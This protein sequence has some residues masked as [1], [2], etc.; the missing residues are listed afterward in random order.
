MKIELSHD[1]LAKRIYD[2]A[3]AEDKMLLRIR[4]LLQDH[5]VNKKGERK[6]LLSK[7]DLAYI[8]P[9]LDSMELSP[10]EVE[11]INLSKKVIQQR[12]HRFYTAFVFFI[13]V[14][15]VINYTARRYKALNDVL[16][17]ELEEKNMALAEEQMKKDAADARADSLYKILMA[18][19]PEFAK[20][21][22]NSYDTLKQSQNA[23]KTELQI[24]QSSTLSSLAQTALEENDINYAFQLASKSWE[25]N[26]SNKQA[27]DLLY[28]I[29]DD[30]SY[31]HH[32]HPET[33]TETETDS[34]HDDLIRNLIA[35]ERSKG[36][37]ELDEKAM[38][39]IF[40]EQNTIVKDKN[41]GG[42]K[43]KVNRMLDQAEKFY[44]NTKNLYK[45]VEK[46]VRETF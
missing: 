33:E 25:L 23:L 4:Q 8:K 2:M 38:E 12:K 37:G 45:D 43:N 24:A 44:G 28:A 29:N 16:V 27:C 1:I 46:S 19:N 20:E 40:D 9:F 31:Q 21:L 26:H 39:V 5:L 36:R 6:L 18:T 30:P 3:S 35:E 42:L 32:D 11:L 14:F 34:L 7:D 17:E 15:L 41:K 13:V 10:A 22:I